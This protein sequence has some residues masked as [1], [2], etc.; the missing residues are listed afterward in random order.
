MQDINIHIEI[1][2][3]NYRKWSRESRHCF[4][5]SGLLHIVYCIVRYSRTLMQHVCC[6][7]ILCQRTTWLTY[8]CV[9]LWE[10]HT[11]EQRAI[12]ACVQCWL[13]LTL[14]RG[15][16]T[17][18]SS[19][20]LVGRVYMHMGQWQQRALQTNQCISYCTCCWDIRTY[21]RIRVASMVIA[22]HI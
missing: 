21:M 19:S 9:Y 14:L 17:G 11:I 8:L 16:T 10:L 1:H 7:S 12:A 4:C 2:G 22:A 6:T 20:Q 3:Y 18:L 13:L 5:L 15:S